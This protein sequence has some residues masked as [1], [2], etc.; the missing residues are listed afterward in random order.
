MVS[1]KQWTAFVQQRQ[2]ERERLQR[3]FDSLNSVATQLGKHGENTAPERE[4]MRRA[5]DGLDNLIADHRRR[6]LH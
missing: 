2:S 1:R 3:A 6:Y 5:I 4:Q